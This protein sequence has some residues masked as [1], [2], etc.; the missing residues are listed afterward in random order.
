MKNTKLPLQWKIIFEFNPRDLVERPFW[1]II[2]MKEHPLHFLPLP[3]PDRSFFAFLVYF[4]GAVS[5]RLRT[6]TLT[7]DQLPGTPDEWIR[8]EITHE[9]EEEDSKYFLSLSV[10]GMEPRRMEAG[11]CGN[12]EVKIDTAQRYAQLN[13]CMFPQGF[14]LGLIRGFVVLG[15]Q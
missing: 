2:G 13:P 3:L 10:N 8:V 7:I 15:K 12:I 14:R 6:G 1:D 4:S 9:E 11:C 5:L